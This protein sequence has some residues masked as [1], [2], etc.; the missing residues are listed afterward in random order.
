MKA[1]WIDDDEFMTKNLIQLFK[2][3]GISIDHFADYEEGIEKLKQTQNISFI[4]LDLMMPSGNLSKEDTNG[5]EYTGIKV[6][7]LIRKVYGGPI[8]LYSVHRNMDKFSNTLSKDRKLA[9][10]PKPQS[11]EMI[12]KTLSKI[13]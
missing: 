7:E 1:I 9:F 4:L 12:L 5:G 3:Y 2:L 6:Y 13:K 10:L 11:P 8:I